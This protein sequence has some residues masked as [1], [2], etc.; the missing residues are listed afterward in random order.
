[1]TLQSTAGWETRPKESK[2][3]EKVRETA[4]QTA[5]TR[6]AENKRSSRS[7]GK[8]INELRVGGIQ[9]YKTPYKRDR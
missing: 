3:R 9:I 1:M 5:R 2:S 4:K 6:Q 8:K 7:P